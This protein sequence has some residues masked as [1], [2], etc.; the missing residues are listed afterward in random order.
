MK[1]MCM[2][3]DDNLSVLKI[4][5]G[6]SLG[7]DD[8]LKYKEDC[9]LQEEIYGNDNDLYSKE[10]I[11]STDLNHRPFLVYEAYCL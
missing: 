2:I 9:T 6:I 5:D 10:F 7:I 8:I 4:T 3:N 1:I 11:I